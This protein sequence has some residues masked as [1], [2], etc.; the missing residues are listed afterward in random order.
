MI[1]ID[2]GTIAVFVVVTIMAVTIA[3]IVT[4][5]TWAVLHI[6]AWSVQEGAFRTAHEQ[7]DHA[8]AIMLY[9]EHVDVPWTP[10]NL[11][12]ANRPH[13][14]TY[15]MDV[16]KSYQMTGRPD[17]AERYYLAVIGW[18]ARQYEAYCALNNACDAGAL[19]AHLQANQGRGDEVE[20]R[21]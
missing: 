20:H 8:G 12:L 11:R 16:A 6:N 19:A 21:P 3:A 9:E 5:I 10:M 13:P 7:G 17:E 15:T 18:T 2:K 4:P 1:K 14:R